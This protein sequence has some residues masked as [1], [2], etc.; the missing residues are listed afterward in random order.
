[1][2]EVLLDSD[3]DAERGDLDGPRPHACHSRCEQL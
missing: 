2:G 1:M 3:Y